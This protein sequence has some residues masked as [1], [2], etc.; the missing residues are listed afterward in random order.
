MGG[1]ISTDQVTALT[2]DCP[3]PTITPDKEKQI[4]N[5]RKLKLKDK[6]IASSLDLDLKQVEAVKC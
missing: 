6:D 3:A 4:C 2:Q 5:L 1:I